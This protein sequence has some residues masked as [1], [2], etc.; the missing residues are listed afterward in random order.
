MIL[1]KDLLGDVVWCFCQQSCLYLELHDLESVQEE[2]DEGFAKLDE[3]TD[4]HVDS[5]I[6]ELDCWLMSHPFDCC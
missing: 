1:F 4:V 6:V 3:D 5:L 2:V